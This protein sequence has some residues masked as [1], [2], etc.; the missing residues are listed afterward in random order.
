MSE[1]INPII[2]IVSPVYNAEQVL[3]ELVQR[4]ETTVQQFTNHYE[5]I[6]VEDRGPDQ[7]WNIIKD[8]AAKNTK[9]KGLKLSR[10]FGQ[11]YAI[12]A[13]LDHSQGEWIVVMDCDLQ[14]VPEEIKNLYIKAQEGYDVVLARRKV[15]KDS[16]SKRLFSNLFYRFLG[17]LTGSKHDKGVANFGIYHQK[18]IRSVNVM[19][20][21]IRF[22]PTMVRWVG[23]RQ[24]IIDVNHAA[25]TEG[26]TNYNFKR[27]LRLALDIILAYSDK[28]IRLTIKF[29]F[30]MAIGAL[31]MALITFLRW[32]SGDIEVLGYTSLIISIWLLSGILLSTLGVIGLYVGKTFEG[33]K[34]RPI[35]FVDESVNEYA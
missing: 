17:Y 11:H 31:I 10:N 2:S 12:T 28:P 34:N 5:I 26:E 33:V 16:F 8:I 27:L 24:T 20:E 7:S 13:G 19:R 32:L 1:K 35:Y 3:V 22:F 15:R 21:S 18:V 30:L 23:Y 4:I 6:L 29:G 9:V 25:R 14:D